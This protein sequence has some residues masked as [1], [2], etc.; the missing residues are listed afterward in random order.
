M[1]KVPIYVFILTNNK[2]NRKNDIFINLIYYYRINGIIQ[3]NRNVLAIGT[4]KTTKF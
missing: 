2:F 3:K 1:L 4:I